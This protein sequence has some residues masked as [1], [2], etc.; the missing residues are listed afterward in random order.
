MFSRLISKRQSFVD[1]GQ[2]S[3][4]IV[5]CSIGFEF[6][7]QTLKQRRMK[8]VSLLVVFRQQ[9]SKVCDTNLTLAESGPRPS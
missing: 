6:G 5:I 3:L 9:P 8:L 2:S 4:C 1:T 7:E